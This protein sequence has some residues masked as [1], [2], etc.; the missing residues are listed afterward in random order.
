MAEMAGMGPG[1]RV[2]LRFPRAGES[3]AAG[4]GCCVLG[5]GA[6]EAARPRLAACPRRTGACVAL[7]GRAGGVY[8]EV[9]YVLWSPSRGGGGEGK[10]RGG[11]ER[12]RARARETRDNN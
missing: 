3:G 6:V 7:G 9:Q 10:E 12:E 8:Y 5:V 4:A 2:R 1:A 11:G